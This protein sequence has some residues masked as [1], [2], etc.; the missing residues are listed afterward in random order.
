MEQI[1]DI[2]VIGGGIVGLA[3]ALSLA[4]R[5]PDLRLVLIEKEYS[6]AVHQTG[7]NSGVI[8]SG[9]YYKPG[10]YKAVLCVQGRQQLLAFAAEHGIPYDICGK[11]IVATGAD[12]HNTLQML[13]ERGRTNGIDDLALID[14]HEIRLRE[15]HCSGLR[16]LY[17][18][19]AG[20]TNYA[21]IAARIASHLTERYKAHIA[22]GQR[23]IRIAPQHEYKAIHTQHTVFRS[24]YIVACAGL[25]A[26]RIA[27]MDGLQPGLR[28]VGFRGDYYDLAPHARHKV[29]S[30]IYPVPDTR[31]PFLGV[32][33]TR[34]IDGGVECGPNAVLSFKREGYNKTDFSLRDTADALSYKGLR[35]LAQKHWRYGLYEYKRAFSQQHFLRSLQRLVPSLQL[36]DIVPARAG[37]RAVAIAPD[38]SLIDDFAIAKGERS[39]HV[40]SAPSPAATA[41]LAIGD[42]LCTMAAEHFAL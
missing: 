35:A 8:H 30:L 21:R 11:L 22:T 31:F 16:A 29:R 38:G 42:T 23:V 40:L 12:E 9:I 3:T 28:I 39:L 33:C 19:S 1:A 18:P 4:Q 7:H 26:D 5:F 37:V 24:R 34:T 15:P 27:T 32:H 14:A 41:S 10:S 20:I 13:Y 6:V 36:S 25:H 2:A 17:V